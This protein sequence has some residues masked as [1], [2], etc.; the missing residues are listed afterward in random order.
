MTLASFASMPH[1][2]MHD[3]VH[4]DRVDRGLV[5]DVVDGRGVYGPAVIFT[6]AAW[7]PFVAAVKATP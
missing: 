3:P 5:S 2:P 7:L 6:S 4:A 1:E